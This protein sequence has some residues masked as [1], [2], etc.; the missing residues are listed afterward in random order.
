ML[1]ACK[2]PPS[3]TN[4]QSDSLL[5]G[6]QSN[7]SVTEKENNNH[8]QL[9]DVSDEKITIA[10]NKKVF[11][12]SG[13]TI[14][15][16]INWN[17]KELNAEDATS[18]FFRHPELNDKCEFIY[19]VTSTEFFSKKRTEEE[20]LEYLSYDNHKDIKIDSFTEEKVGGYNSTKIVSFYS[21]E[22]SKFI[23][24]DYDYIVIGV[25][26]YSFT[27]TYPVSEADDLASIFDS[28]VNSIKFK[29]D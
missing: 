9:H 6:T 23:R 7:N 19:E 25:R 5:N 28:I 4:N 26:L 20:Y 12:D 16:P 27:I 10:E 8:Y 18:Y 14:S 2:Q 29:D 13:I 15:L 3:P 17:C 11:S 1:S 24:I 22:N 21:F